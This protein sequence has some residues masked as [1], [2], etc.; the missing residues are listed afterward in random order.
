[1]G[2]AYGDGLERGGTSPDEELMAVGSD[3][4]LED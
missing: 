4:A 2:R 3:A 1:M